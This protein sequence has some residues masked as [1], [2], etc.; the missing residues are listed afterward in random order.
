MRTTKNKI[1]KA[2]FKRIPKEDTGFN[3]I[4]ENYI[5][6]SR[7]KFKPELKEKIIFL[8]NKLDK[9]QSFFIPRTEMHEAT[10]RVVIQEERKSKHNKDKDIRICT[11]KDSE[12]KGCRIAR[13]Y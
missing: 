2:K 6:E 13:F 7:V 12:V 5:P 4:I 8:M 3:P 9:G 11:S 10:I 1:E